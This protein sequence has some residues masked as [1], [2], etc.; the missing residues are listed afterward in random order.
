MGLRL[1]AKSSLSGPVIT[2]KI[3]EPPTELH[4]H[5]NLLFS[6]ASY[7]RAALTSSWLESCG[8][9]CL[10][11]HDPEIVELYVQY[12]YTGT[13]FSATNSE[14]IN[15]AQWVDWDQSWDKTFSLYF[16]ADYV[17]DETLTNATIDV[18]IDKAQTS[19][20]YPIGYAE[21]V[22]SRSAPGS[23]IRKLLVDF[24][25]HL[26][27]CLELKDKDCDEK[28]APVEFLKDVIMEMKKTLAKCAEPL[29]GRMKWFSDEGCRRYHDHSVVGKEEGCCVVSDA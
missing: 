28:N 9:V 29:N 11:E 25:V 3:G 23:R 17:G 21:M 20:R 4:A 24:H 27:L 18:L 1:T 5:R 8:T 16:L 6:S 26:G 13:V 14:K 12:L 19:Q 7:F 15:N 2:L 22:Y 10:P